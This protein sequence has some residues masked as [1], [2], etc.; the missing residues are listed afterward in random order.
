MS[1]KTSTFFWRYSWNAKSRRAVARCAPEEKT[2][3]P[4]PTLRPGLWFVLAPLRV[5]RPAADWDAMPD[6]FATISRRSSSMYEWVSLVR[7][8]GGSRSHASGCGSPR[9]L[10]SRPGRCSRLSP[11][12]ARIHGAP[13]AASVFVVGSP[14]SIPSPP[15]P[16]IPFHPLCAARKKESNV[17]GKGLWGLSA[18]S[19]FSPSGV[20]AGEKKTRLCFSLPPP[21]LPASPRACCALSRRGAVLLPLRVWRGFLAASPFS[22]S[23]GCRVVPSKSNS[24]FLPTE[25]RQKKRKRLSVFSLYHARTRL[26]RVK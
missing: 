10:R 7:P 16:P 4:A 25:G 13:S 26:S 17:G 1:D 19:G 24:I 8:V 2:R 15:R 12:I 23:R 6:G 5:S 18:P 20:P 22:C 9:P 3:P 11:V 14:P 21:P